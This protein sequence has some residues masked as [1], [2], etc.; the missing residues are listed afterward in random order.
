MPTRPR[1]RRPK[2][3]ENTSRVVLIVDNDE[4]AREVMRR[5]LAHHGIEALPVSSAATAIALLQ[6]G[7]VAVL[8]TDYRMPGVDGMQ[9]MALVRRDYPRT[10]VIIVTGGESG[11]L[12][13]RATALGV[14]VLLKPVPHYDLYEQ[15]D[16]QLELYAL[17]AAE[18]EDTAPNGANGH[19]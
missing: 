9:L 16:H 15:V 2:R 13:A 11:E 17:A 3:S 14:P 7:P 5:T 18:E 6:A 12:V 10:R 8:V 1:R 4:A 19:K